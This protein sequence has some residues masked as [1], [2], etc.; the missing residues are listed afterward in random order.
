MHRHDGAGLGR[1]GSLDL[2]HVDVLR[3]RLDV[4]KDGGR[5]RKPNGFGG[6]EKGVGGG[7]D[8]V[9]WSDPECQKTEQQGIRTRVHP[10]RFL[11][12]HVLGQLLL[13]LRELRTEHI[14]AA[15]EHVV[16][17]LINVLLEVAILANMPV[18]IHSHLSHL[19]PSR[20]RDFPTRL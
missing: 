10:D 14:G 16:N 18:E 7:D 2:G 20:G 19:R 1:D 4:D 15:L 8:L 3:P 5:A 13:E 17:G 9:P 11:H 12:A 6:G